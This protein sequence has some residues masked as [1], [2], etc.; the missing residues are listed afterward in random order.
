MSVAL[1]QGV[2]GGF[3]VVLLIVLVGGGLLLAAVF[4]RAAGG[5]PDDR[6]DV[7]ARSGLIPGRIL[8]TI[9]L[10]S[11]VIGAFF[12]SIGSDIMGMLLGMMGYYFGARVFGV[13]V[14]VLS[15]V[16]LFVGLLVGQGVIPGSYDQFV[17]GFSRPQGG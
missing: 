8:C 16:T 6:P 10:G 13:V 7:G 2:A 15:T 5:R 3:L 1:L 4:G 14:I 17:E 12:V 11:A 9:G